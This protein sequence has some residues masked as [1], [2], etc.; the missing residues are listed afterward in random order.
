MRSRLVFKLS[1]RTSAM[2][3]LVRFFAEGANDRYDI[4]DG[5]YCAAVPIVL[6]VRLGA[7]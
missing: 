3:S 5:L 4:L 1:L 6:L 2:S 7:W